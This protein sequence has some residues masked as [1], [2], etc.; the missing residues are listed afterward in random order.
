MAE[1]YG[2]YDTEELVDGTYDR[3]YV[4][5]QWAD[6]FSLF[7]GTGVFASP[8]NQLK[9][10]AG[11]GMEIIVK[12]GWAFIEGRWYHNDADLTLS[13]Q[14]NTTTSTITSGVF[15]Q[16]DSANREIKAV[17]AT[18]RTTPDRESS[19]YELELAQL[20]IETGT[21]AITD[22]MITDMR[23]DESVCG[24][25]KGL[26]E[27]VI[28]TA[29]LFLQFETQFMNW[30]EEMK[31]Q[32]SEDAAGNLQLEIDDIN[33][34]IDDINQEIN[35]NVYQVSDTA[36]TTINDTDYV[37]LAT[38]DGTKK[39]TLITTLRDKLASFF[40]LNT[41]GTCSTAAAT[42]AKVVTISNSNWKLTV[43]AKVTVKFTYT[44]T[45]SNPTLNV[46]GTGAK[47]IWYNT[48]VITTSNLGHG[49]TANRNITYVY[50]GTYWVVAS[51]GV[52]T[53]TTTGTTYAAASIPS[54]TTFGTNGSIKN[55]YNVVSALNKSA[56]IS[57]ITSSTV[58][59]TSFVNTISKS[60]KM[61]HVH[62]VFTPSSAI[63][64]G[65][66]LYTISTDYLTRVSYYLTFG[67]GIYA[68]DGSDSLKRTSINMSNGS[69]Y[70]DEQLLAGVS[71]VMDLTFYNNM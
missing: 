27:G 15:I 54:N 55:V 13:V 44:N 23:T 5:Q 14:P 47:S 17:I 38:T 26:L 64:A 39:K 71:Y 36:S 63:S 61:T 58:D 24:F 2:F 48:S 70:S 52:D 66:S 16:A 68:L 57:S 41:Y 33:Q 19:Y 37:P 56:T 50:D 30:F 21:T 10:V 40:G 49:G 53:N 35:D 34:E 1:T 59:T 62:V 43:G 45:A 3:E 46:N 6:Y 9:V 4:A 65:T 20:Q 22:A 11:D 51:T 28:P 60:G 7:I 67:Y 32:L 31:D 12:E 8:T 69:I 42:T 18:G 29:D 25:V